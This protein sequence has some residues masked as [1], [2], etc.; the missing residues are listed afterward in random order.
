MKTSS[1]VLEGKESLIHISYLNKIHHRLSQSQQI[2]FNVS[3]FE[4]SLLVG[5]RRRTQLVK[6]SKIRFRKMWGKVKNIIFQKWT[7]IY[8]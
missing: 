4:T 6:G 1:A 2:Y 3:V 8:T 5:P 7:C